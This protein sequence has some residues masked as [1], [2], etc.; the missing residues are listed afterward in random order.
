MHTLIVGRTL[1]GKTTFAKKKAASLKKLGRPI[2]VLDPFL[3]PQWNADF[4]TSN[5]DEFLK[6]F[7]NNRSCAVFID[8]S[9]RMIGKYNSVMEDCATMGRHWGHKVYFITQRVKQ[10]STNIRTQ[11]SELVIFKQSLA[12]TKDLA[13]EFVEPMINQAHELN[14]GEFIYVRH[15]QPSQKLNVFEI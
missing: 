2:I 8:E 13:D 14:Q 10:I 1:S 12:D 4:I 7:W 15:G 9:G 6:A 3:D 11:C 5:Q